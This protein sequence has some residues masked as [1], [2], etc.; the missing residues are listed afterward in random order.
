MN[1]KEANEMVWC[2]LLLCLGGLKV[3]FFL[4]LFPTISKKLSLNFATSGNQGLIN[5][6]CL[7]ICI[8]SQSILHQQMW[9]L[10]ACEKCCPR[11][12]NLT[13]TVVGKLILSYSF[14]HNQIEG[15]NTVQLRGT[16]PTYTQNLGKIF[17]FCAEKKTRVLCAFSQSACFVT[18]CFGKQRFSVSKC[19]RRNINSTVVCRHLR[20]STTCHDSTRILQNKFLKFFKMWIIKLIPDTGSPSSSCK[21][22]ILRNS[23]HGGIIRVWMGIYLRPL[24][25]IKKYVKF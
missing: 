16:W 20:D 18:H 15:S 17:A 3:V 2:N 5:Y 14:T 25:G 8:F 13:C 19:R 21:M 23:S 10:H 12:T 22:I 1:E 7:L 6:L 24:W 9:I 4:N 11:K